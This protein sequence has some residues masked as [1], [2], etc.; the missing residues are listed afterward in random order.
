MRFFFFIIICLLLSF[1]CRNS[2]QKS[3]PQIRGICLLTADKSTT[4]DG[5]TSIDST[6]VFKFFKDDHVIYKLPKIEY[7]DSRTKMRNDT[8]DLEFFNPDTTFRYFVAKNNSDFGIEYDN[9]LN[10]KN[11]VNMDSL[12]KE[13]GVHPSMFGAYKL[14]LGKPAKIEKQ[15]TDIQ[16]EKYLN[17]KLVEDD[18]DSIYR[19]F[20]K[21]LVEINFSFSPSLDKEKNS[22]LF[23]T[24]FIHTYNDKK[25]NRK[26]ILRSEFYSEFKRISIVDPSFY[27]SLIK[28]Y[29]HDKKIMGLS[30]L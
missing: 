27:I 28:K 1:G 11:K 19:Y 24:S 30:K 22:K 3:R 14:D 12:L 9:N 5:I 13:I 29:E 15:T 6:W 21:S 8:I 10:R 17:K 18:S 2:F 23:K 7:K 26:N 25:V 20:D 16:I 4:L